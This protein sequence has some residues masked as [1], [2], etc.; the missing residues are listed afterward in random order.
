MYHSGT[1]V[2]QTIMNSA[3]GQ[4]R[5]KETPPGG[6]VLLSATETKSG[7]PGPRTF[8]STVLHK[9]SR[10]GSIASDADGW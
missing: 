6:G 5:A 8:L 7:Q 1:L 10:L 2:I 4:V 9:L 3:G